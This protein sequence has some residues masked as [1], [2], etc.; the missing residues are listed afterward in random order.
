MRHLIL[1]LA[2]VALTACNESGG[3]AETAALPADSAPPSVVTDPG[4]PDAG[5][6]DPGAP[7]PVVAAP[8]AIPLTIYSLSRTIAPSTSYP[9]LTFTALASC[10]E[11]NG[12]QYCWD[13]G[14][15]S[16]TGGPIT[17]SDNYFGLQTHA[18]TGNPQSC[19]LTCNSSYMAPIRDVTAYRNLSMI[20]LG[21][22][23]GQEIDHILANGTPTQTSCT[24]EDDTL[25]CGT[26]VINVGQ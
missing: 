1:I 24:L 14:L 13:D 8:T 18:T 7:A 23:L 16:T 2:T 12:R 11:Y 25:T 9:T 19:K 15:H 3:G 17:F 21:G 5:V 10:A 26:L 20:V 22:T 6:V 4:T